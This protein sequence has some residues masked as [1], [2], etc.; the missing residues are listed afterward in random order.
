VSANASGLETTCF[1]MPV[2]I[3]IDRA[4]KIIFSTF[5]GE[6]SEADFRSAVEAMPTQ[7]GFDSTFSHIIDLSSVTALK[8]SAD[9]VRGM[10][11][12]PSVFTREARQ[13]VVAPQDHVFG[14][15]RM[16]QILGEQERP[17]VA[18][19]RSLTAACEILGIQLSASE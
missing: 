9:F 14:L 4:A 13:I 18:V 5:Q 2:T 6:I 7:P 1:R 15:A 8:V 16:A 12:Q 17:H 11:Q 10:A 3:Q 19:V